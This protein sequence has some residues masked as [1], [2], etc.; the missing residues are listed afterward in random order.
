MSAGWFMRAADHGHGDAAFKLANAHKLGL[1]IPQNIEQAL[2]LYQNASSNG[3]SE[4]A[5]AL[6]RIYRL[7]DGVRRDYP[8][9]LKW[10]R[11]LADKGFAP[12]EH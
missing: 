1:G 2:A 11:V 4:A 8:K 12:A 7:G 10:L 6:G 9:A 3:S 5:Y